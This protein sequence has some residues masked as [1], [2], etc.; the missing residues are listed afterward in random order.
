M[1]KKLS[2][3]LTEMRIQCLTFFATCQGPGLSHTRVVR[4]IPERRHVISVTMTIPGT[5][6]F[7]CCLV[8]LVVA[9]L[10]DEPGRPVSE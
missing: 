4:S 8:F 6:V 3:D 1:G 10:K 7:F 2:W 9:S 5:R